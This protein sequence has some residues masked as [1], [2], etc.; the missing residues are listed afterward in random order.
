MHF[1]AMFLKQLGIYLILIQGFNALKNSYFTSYKLLLIIA[2]SL[3]TYLS[4]KNI[5]FL[6]QV[7]IYAMLVVSNTHLSSHLH[8]Y[9]HNNDPA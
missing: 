3:F 5:Q 6:I 9:N 2:V 1:T 7:L 8:T 4:E